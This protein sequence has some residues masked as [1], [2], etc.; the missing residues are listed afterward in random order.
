M[1]R[2]YVHRSA[3]VFK[4]LAV[5]FEIFVWRLSTKLD[6]YGDKNEKKT[7]DEKLLAECEPLNK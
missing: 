5:L 4:A 1:F 3:A 2:K 6:L 7:H